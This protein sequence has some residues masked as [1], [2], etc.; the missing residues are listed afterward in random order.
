MFRPA[1]L[2]SGSSLKQSEWEVLGFT[3]LIYECKD[4]AYVEM[5]QGSSAL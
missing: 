5:M 3:Y 1:W 4:E 2:F